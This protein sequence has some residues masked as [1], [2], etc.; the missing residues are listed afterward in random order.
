MY[1]YNQFWN[2]IIILPLLSIAKT[3][4]NSPNFASHKLPW[5]NT[6]FEIKYVK[7]KFYTVIQ[8]QIIIELL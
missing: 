7:F 1:N 3:L 8:S 2:E 4:D 5:A 6:Q